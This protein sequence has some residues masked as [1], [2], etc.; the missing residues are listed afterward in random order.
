M[1]IQVWQVFEP[2]QGAPDADGRVRCFN[3]LQD[4]T[5]QTQAEHRIKRLN[6]VYAVLSGINTTIVRVRE[7]GELFRDA[8]RI[9]VDAGQFGLAW[10]GIADHKAKRLNPVAWHGAGEGYIELMPLGLDENSPESFGLAGRAVKERKPMISDD[11]ATA[12]R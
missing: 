3:T 9:A 1:W 6:R 11:M 4:V 5:E 2:I 10:I 8:C 12:R 7:R